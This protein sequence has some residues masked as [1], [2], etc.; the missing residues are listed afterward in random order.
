MGYDLFLASHAMGGLIAIPGFPQRNLASLFYPESSGLYQ[1]EGMSVLVTRG[2]SS[3]YPP[4][5][6][7][8]WPEINLLTLI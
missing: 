1:V 4:L 8:A 5:R 7:W 3:P 6:L 2:L